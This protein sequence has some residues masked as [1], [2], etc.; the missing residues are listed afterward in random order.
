[1][2]AAA[3]LEPLMGVAAM[4]RADEAAPAHG[5]PSM[6]LMEN[7]GRAVADEIGRRFPPCAT[8]VLCGP[9]NNGG[10]GYVAAR[11]LKRRGWP[12]RCAALGDPG[13]LKG[14]A[15]AAFRRWDGE[16]ARLGEDAPQAELYVDA[17]FGAGLSRPLEGVAAALARALPPGRVVAVDVPSGVHGDT[18]LAPGGVSYSAA[19]TVTFVRRK[20]G[21]ALTP[22]R[23]LC[24]ALVVAD[25]GMPEAALAAA[26][27]ERV[28][29]IV[30]G[31]AVAGEPAAH[32]DRRGHALVVSGGWESTGA[33]R[34]A[35]LVRRGP[36]R[37]W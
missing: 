28:W 35:A 2:R 6:T 3:I 24:G 8:V 21:H 34:L 30:G 5:A 12:V 14:D 27:D 20:P 19:V 13:A 9:G 37:V 32:K 29:A 16:T 15:A 31:R 33:A 1:M 17:L 10:D 4:A 7:A 26:G 36:G 22:G 11:L 18:G 25:I 23:A